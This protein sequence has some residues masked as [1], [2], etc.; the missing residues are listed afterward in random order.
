MEGELKTEVIMAKISKNFEVN[1]PAGVVI[2]V[3]MIRDLLQ[4]RPVSYKDLYKVLDYMDKMAKQ[5]IGWLR[6][7]AAEGCVP[8]TMFTEFIHGKH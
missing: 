5:E 2:G 7:L 8:T 3:Q 4:K 6:H 1:A